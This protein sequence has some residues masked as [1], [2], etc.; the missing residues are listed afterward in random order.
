MKFIAETEVL[1]FDKTMEN[2]GKATGEIKPLSF[3]P[4]K[5][6]SKT[7]KSSPCAPICVQPELY[8]TF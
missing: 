4:E 7:S 3:F 1:K 8:K 5:V 6:N 2:S